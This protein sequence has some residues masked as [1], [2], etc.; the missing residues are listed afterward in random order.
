[1]RHLT[2][3]EVMQFVDATADYATMAFST[4]HLAVCERCRKEIEFQKLV[5][6]AIRRIP[7][8]EAS[9]SITDTTMSLILPSLQ[10]RLGSRILNNL[11]P[12]FGLIMVISA[13][14]LLYSLVMKTQFASEK[15]SLAQP[16]S[17]VEIAKVVISQSVDFARALP[18]S[19]VAEAIGKLQ[20]PLAWSS[21]ILVLLLAFDRLIAKRAIRTIRKL[22]V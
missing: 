14:G 6:K 12:L 22:K 7:L 20:R 10:S 21:V 19:S 5:T 1:M 16:N 13:G 4:N 18:L 17:L 8:P 2:T 11:G 9:S 3:A 15:S